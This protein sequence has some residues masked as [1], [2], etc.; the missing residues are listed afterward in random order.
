MRKSTAYAGDCKGVLFDGPITAKV[1]EYVKVDE[2]LDC[3]RPVLSNV[4][5]WYDG[6]EGSTEETLLGHK[7]SAIYI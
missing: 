4:M 1:Y 3:H 2:L 6:T 7:D 5:V